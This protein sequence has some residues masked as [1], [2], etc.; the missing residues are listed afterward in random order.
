[1]SP[2]VLQPLRI[3]GCLG[4]EWRPVADSFDGYPVYGGLD[5]SEVADLTAF[6]QIAH[7]DG[8]WHVKPTFWLPGEDLVERSRKDRVPYDQFA[9]EGY[10]ET[11][12]GRL[13]EY[14]YVAEYLYQ[15]CT[16]KDMR[17]IAFDRSNMRALRPWLYRAGFPEEQLENDFAIFQAFGPGCQSMSPALR[18][19]ESILLTQKLTHGDHPVLKMCAAN[20]VVQQHPSDNRKLTGEEPWPDR[21]DG[22]VAMAVSVATTDLQA[23]PPASP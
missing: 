10:L 11:T 12:P 16:R 3:A 1:M 22:G 20:A 19:L 2:Y 4:R 7:I 9:R 13:V 15:V 5:L 17:N 6:V 8:I 21:R 18:E 14:E 23:Q